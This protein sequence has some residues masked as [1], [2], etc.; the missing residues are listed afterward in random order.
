MVPVKISYIDVVTPL[1]EGTE[2]F[3]REVARKEIAISKNT[4]FDCSAFRSD[5]AALVPGISKNGKTCV[6]QMFD[7]L[8]ER[9]GR[10]FPGD[11]RLIFAATVGEIENLENAVLN[12]G[13]KGPGSTLLSTASRLA[14]SLELEKPPYVVS[15][16]CASAAAAVDRAKS[17]IRCGEERSV[18]VASADCVSEFVFSGFS[19][20][21]ALDREAARPFDENRDGL[22]A[23]EAAGFVLLEAAT[24]VQKDG[25]YITGSGFSSDANHM[26]GPSRDG[27][28]LAKA[29]ASAVESAGLK[30][31]SVD[32]IAAHGTGTRYN[33]AMEIKAYKTV[34]DTPCPMFSLK[35]AVGH[36]MGNAGLLQLAVAVESMKNRTVPPST[37]LSCVDEESAG[38]VTERSVAVDS[39]HALI[40]NAGFGGI[41]SALVLSRGICE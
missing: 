11:T 9:R 12:D 25:F 24:D 37:G 36:T 5:R 30:P 27:S 23:G 15:A 21:M 2:T 35:G 1:G 39:N 40:V 41:N 10:T 22:T 18:L 29:V 26:T 38:W 32:F 13:S 33:D 34:F 31:G 6:A 19:A 20:L 8:A 4:R 16:A 7:M 14:E 28:G 17:L 3:Y